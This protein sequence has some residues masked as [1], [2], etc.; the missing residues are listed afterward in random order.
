MLPLA[1]RGGVHTVAAADVL[2]TVQAALRASLATVLLFAVCG[3]G[4]DAASPPGARPRIRDPLDAG[5]RRVRVGARADGARLR[6]RALQA[7]ARD[8]DRG[9]ARA[10][11]WSRC[12]RTERKPP[13]VRPVLWPALV[14]VLLTAVALIP[15]FAAGFPTVTGDGSD[16][17]H[18][19]GAAEFLQHNHPTAV[20]PDGPLDEMPPLWRSKQP[21]Y[22]VLGAA[23]TLSGLEPYEVLAPVAAVVFALASLGM[24][25]LARALLGASV[26]AGL[27]AAAIT[28]L[29]AMVL[30]TVTAPLLQ[31]DMGLLRVHLLARARVVGRARPPSRRR[32]RCSS[33]FMVLGALAYP[34][35]LPIP[36][37]ALDRVLPGRPARAAGAREDRPACRMR[38]RSGAA[39]AGSRGWCRRPSCSRSRRPRAPTR[40]GTRRACSS[41]RTARSRGWAGDI[42]AVHPGAPVLRAA[43]GHAVVARRRGHGRATIWLLTKLPRPLGWGIAAVLVGFLARGRVVPPA[44]P[45]PVLRVQDARVRGAAPGGVRGRRA[46]AAPPRRRLPARGP[47]RSRASVGARPVLYT[48]SQINPALLDLREWARDLPADAS[49]RLDTWPPRQLWGSYMLARQPLCSQLPLLRTAYPRV[50]DLAQG[51]LHPRRPGRPRVLRRRAPGRRR[52]AAAHQHR[53]RAL[54]DEGERPGPRELLEAPRLRHPL[55]RGVD[56]LAQLLPGPLRG[57]CLKPRVAPFDQ[58]P[59]QLLVVASASA[60]SSATTPRSG[61]S[62]VQ[63][64]ASPATSGMPPAGRA[65]TGT[66]KWNASSSGMQKPSCS[67]RESTTVPPGSARAAVVLERPRELDV[68]A[69]RPARRASSSC[70]RYGALSGSPAQQQP[71]VRRE[72]ALVERERADH[73]VVALVRREPARRT[74]PAAGRGRLRLG[75]AEQVGLEQDRHD[76]HVAARRPRAARAR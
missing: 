14:G 10:R 45:R 13:P 53:L 51:R 68:V 60:S 41:T 67:E 76:A 32:S 2:D 52:P 63:S 69:R 27:L 59:A 5:D 56:R 65:I 21:I 24:F 4:V 33:L 62:S 55:T 61:S 28:G 7:L 58:R 49:V 48:G 43:D 31:P 25:V 73:E 40:P 26:L 37:L 38:R 20:N 15:Y 30:E 74:G 70:S 16:A 66:P 19:V 18:A 17:F 64:A 54:P 23:A 72:L 47:A 34:L 11:R 42:F 39:G 75:R 22:Y 6:L 35:A 8:H 12:R 46:V 3:F 44:R 1:A 29:N 71:R 57:E 36:G 9:R 50:R